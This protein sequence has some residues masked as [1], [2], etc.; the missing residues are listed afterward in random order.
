MYNGLL[1]RRERLPDFFQSA[2]AKVKKLNQFRIPPV[3]AAELPTFAGLNQGRGFAYL[4]RSINSR[5][6]L[7]K[8]LLT[9]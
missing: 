6:W 9:T 2:D 4:C 1:W 5:Q 3:H 7:S 8:I